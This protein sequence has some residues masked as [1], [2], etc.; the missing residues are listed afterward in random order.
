MKTSNKLGRGNWFVGVFSVVMI[1]DCL[2]QLSTHKSSLLGDW[3][4]YDPKWAAGGAVLGILLLTSAIS[5]G[6]KYAKE[7]DDSDVDR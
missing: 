5:W 3:E 4:K 7:D 1:W 2:V 6:V